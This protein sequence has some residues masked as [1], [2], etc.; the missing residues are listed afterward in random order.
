MA[1]V[2]M[3]LRTMNYGETRTH[4]KKKAI[5]IIFLEMIKKHIFL[6]RLQKVVPL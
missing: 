5:P 3:V 2:E 4:Y 6:R 1:V